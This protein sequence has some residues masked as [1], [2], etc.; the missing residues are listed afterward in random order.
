[1]NAE[2]SRGSPLLIVSHIV[3]LI[4]PPPQQYKSGGDGMHTLRGKAEIEA[5]CLADM[6]AQATKRVRCEEIDAVFVTG[7][8]IDRA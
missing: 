2:Q 5:P 1:V 7:N 3:T 8:E 4:D 6:A